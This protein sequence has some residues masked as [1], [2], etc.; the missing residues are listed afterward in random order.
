MNIAERNSTSPS[1]YISLIGAASVTDFCGPVGPVVTNPIVPIAGQLSTASYPYTLGQAWAGDLAVSGVTK[2]INIDDLLTPTWGLSEEFET[3]QYDSFAG[4][5]RRYSVRTIGP[6]FYPM[7]IPPPE[8]LSLTSEWSV[9]SAFGGQDGEGGKGAYFGSPITYA[10]IDPPQVLTPA[11]FLT[12]VVDEED[13]PSPTDAAPTPKP[14]IPPRLTP[15]AGSIGSPDQLPKTRPAAAAAAASRPT[16]AAVQQDSSPQNPRPGPSQEDPQ[17]PDSEG[18]REPTIEDK[19]RPLKIQALPPK[20]FLNLHLKTI[21]RPLKTR[22]GF[23]KET[24]SHR[25]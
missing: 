17:S 10:I 15:Q 13:G 9:C 14:D 23:H 11:D 2:A 3:S 24:H 12:P 1:V 6:P 5:M 16:N 22:K 21:T 4:S 8:L 7:V 20:G 25:T 19:N 18:L